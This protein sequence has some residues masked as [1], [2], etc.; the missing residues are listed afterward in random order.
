MKKRVS[1]SVRLMSV[2]LTFLLLFTTIAGA[3]ITTA[4]AKEIE[5]GDNVEV[6]ELSNGDILNEGVRVTNFRYSVSG[7]YYYEVYI[8]KE[9][10]DRKFGLSIKIDRRVVLV[11]KEKIRAGTISLYFKSVSQDDKEYT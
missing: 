3:G 2:I 10:I 8:D 1:F 4:S 11:S 5:S 6:C 9:F 7:A